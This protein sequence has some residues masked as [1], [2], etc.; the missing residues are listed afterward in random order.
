M[1]LYG[2]AACTAVEWCQAS[3]HGQVLANTMPR[4]QNRATKGFNSITKTIHFAHLDIL[5]IYL[6]PIVCRSMSVARPSGFMSAGLG[7]ATG[8]ADRH[9]QYTH[10]YIFGTF[11]VL[12]F[13]CFSCN[14]SILETLCLCL[15]VHYCGSYYCKWPKVGHVF[16][17]KQ[18]V[19]TDKKSCHSF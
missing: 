14:S 9:V 1:F 16:T 10:A 2:Q 7:V 3:G 19:H 11:F 6:S 8:G 15:A 18:L 4:A 13:S 17:L 12:L 5:F